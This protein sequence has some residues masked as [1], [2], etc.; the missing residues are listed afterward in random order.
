MPARDE[1][2]HHAQEEGIEFHLLCNPV[3][4][5][6]D[7]HNAV[8]GIRSIRMELGEPDESGRRRPVP[9]PGSEFELPCDVVI[10]AIGNKPNPLIP[11]TTPDIKLTRWGTIEADEKTGQTSKKKV[12]AGGDI[13]S[14]AATVILAMGAGRIA[15]R[16]IHENLSPGK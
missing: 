13:V 7:E 3:E 10:M 4:I 11:N 16:A 5:L 12:Y 6:G 9:V 1:E 15:A 8:R 14:G 2:I